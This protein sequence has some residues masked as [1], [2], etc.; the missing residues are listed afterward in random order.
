MNYY[1]DIFFFFVGFI[2]FY[3]FFSLRFFF[4]FFVVCFVSKSVSSFFLTYIIWRVWRGFFFHYYFFDL[5]RNQFVSSAAVCLANLKWQCPN[6][7]FFFFQKTREKKMKKLH[8]SFDQIIF[9]E[10]KTRTRE[11]D[12]RR[13]CCNKNRMFLNRGKKS[14]IKK[15][16]SLFHSNVHNWVWLNELMFISN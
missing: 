2:S 5:K 1:V 11:Y 15:K 10:F 9:F 8:G 6:V 16:K 7:M 14:N 13:C 12:V 3:L 4:L